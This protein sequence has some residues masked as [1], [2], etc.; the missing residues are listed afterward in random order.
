[1]RYNTFREAAGAIVCLGFDLVLKGLTLSGDVWTG[2]Q[3]INWT[4]NEPSQASSC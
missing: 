4:D 1:V 2:D 3:L